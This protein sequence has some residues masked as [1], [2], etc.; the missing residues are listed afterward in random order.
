[1]RFAAAG[2]AADHNPLPRLRI[3]RHK[4]TA[5]GQ[6]FFRQLP[7]RYGA[8]LIRQILVYVQPEI[9]QRAASQQRRQS[10]AQPPYRLRLFLLTGAGIGVLAVADESGVPAERTMI[11]L[12]VRRGY[13][14]FPFVQ[15]LIQLRPIDKKLF[16]AY[17]CSAVNGCKASASSAAN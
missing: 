9:L 4:I 2:R 16:H 10:G 3:V 14:F 17:S 12:F 1:M 7:I 15:A 11:D 6:R 8:A 13:A 5:D